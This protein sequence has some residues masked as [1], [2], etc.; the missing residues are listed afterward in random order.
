MEDTACIID[1]PLRKFIHWLSSDVEY[2][3]SLL[4]F[5]FALKCIAGRQSLDKSVDRQA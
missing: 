1:Q 4:I 5:N 3:S 2:K